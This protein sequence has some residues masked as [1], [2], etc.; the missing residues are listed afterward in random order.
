M[1]IYM[2]R[3]TTLV[4]PFA[5]YRASLPEKVCLSAW[6]AVH[7]LESYRRIIVYEH[8][9]HTGTATRNRSGPSSETSKFW[10]CQSCADLS[11]ALTDS[12]PSE[13]I[14]PAYHFYSLL[15]AHLRASSRAPTYAGTIERKLRGWSRKP[16][17]EEELSV[18]VVLGGMGKMAGKNFS[19]M[20]GTYNQRL[21]VLGSFVDKV[22]GA[23]TIS[24]LAEVPSAPQAKAIDEGSPMDSISTPLNDITETVLDSLPHLDDFLLSDFQ[25]RI[26]EEDLLA[27][28]KVD[29]DE[30]EVEMERQR[31]LSS[32][33][34]WVR[35]LMVEIDEEGEQGG[36]SEEG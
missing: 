24:K 10:S 29:V 14:L 33:F 23:A 21:E 1:K 26:L 36:E 16:P 4:Q 31:E 32:P 19:V 17:N 12:Y 30:S 7:Y 3:N 6:T 22:E 15:L 2:I 20:K 28:V 8:P 9:K 27:D 5:A 25:R 35:R 11:S 13:R 34:G 18:V